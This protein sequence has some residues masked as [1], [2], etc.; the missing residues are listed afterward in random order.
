MSL[1][2]SSSV[3]SVF[4]FRIHSQNVFIRVLVGYHIFLCFFNLLQVCGILIIGYIHD[5]LPGYGYFTTYWVPWYCGGTF[6]GVTE[7]LSLRWICA[8]MIAGG[9]EHVTCVPPRL[10]WLN[11]LCTP[12]IRRLL[13]QFSCEMLPSYLT[14]TLEHRALCIVSILVHVTHT[15]LRCCLDTA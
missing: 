14:G 11:F 15:D 6:C 12:R 2:E 1:T 3:I 4:S 9:D 7:H 10:Y 5:V 8:S 13:H